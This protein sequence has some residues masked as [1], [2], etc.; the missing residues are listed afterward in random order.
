MQV[1]HRDSLH[2]DLLRA[3]HRIVCKRTAAVGE[4][5]LCR[6][7]SDMDLCCNTLCMRIASR[8]NEAGCLS[9]KRGIECWL[10]EA[11]QVFAIECLKKKSSICFWYSAIMSLHTKHQSKSLWHCTSARCHCAQSMKFPDQ[12]SIAI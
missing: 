7:D 11:I 12:L 9:G 5:D 3:V 4:H 10:R 2:D 8:D 1:L 6:D